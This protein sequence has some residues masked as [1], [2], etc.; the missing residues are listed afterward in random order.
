MVFL[1]LLQFEAIEL[2]SSHLVSI[3]KQASKSW[4]N[5]WVQNPF[6]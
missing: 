1:S 3:F 6:N 4:L 5:L 2:N